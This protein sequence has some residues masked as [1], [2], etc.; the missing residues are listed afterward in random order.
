[1]SDV[2]ASIASDESLDAISEK[3]AAWAGDLTRPLPVKNLLS[4]TWLGHQ[5]HPMLTD[6]PIGAWMMASFLDLTAG[7]AGAKA[8]Q[9]LVGVGLLAT[10]PTAASG[11][12]DWADTYGPDQ[13]IGFVHAAGNVVGALFHATSWLARRR[14]H[15]GAGIVLSGVGLGITAASSYLGGHLSFVKGV[16]VNML[17]HE[18]PVS[19]WTDVAADA[20]VVEGK[21]LRAEAGDVAVVL[22]RYSGRLYAMSAVCTHAGGPLDEGE[23]VHGSIKCPWHGSEF[24]VADG[25]VARGPATVAQPSWEVRVDDGRIQVR[26]KES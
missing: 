4:G 8:A 9:K 22:A 24:R 19:D 12:N 2:I 11:A 3:T 1:M 26:S 20:D 6:V 16:G 10:I 25:T 15:R 23:L 7:K 13:R 14:G 21:L 17:A 5:L 18:E